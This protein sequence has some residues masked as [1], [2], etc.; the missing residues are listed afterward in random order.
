MGEKIK[1]EQVPIDKIALDIR[2]DINLRTY[3][4]LN[5]AGHI[6]KH[7]LRGANEYNI[8]PRTYEKFLELYQDIRVN[9]IKDPIK[10]QKING[11][12]YLEDG[13]HRLAAARA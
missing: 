7:F 9:G 4:L 10:A 13:A 3:V 6:W 11:R 5:R 2:D 12:F 1:F 8:R